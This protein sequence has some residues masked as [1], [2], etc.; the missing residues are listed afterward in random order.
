MS[1][2]GQ[3][4]LNQL[5]LVLNHF[6]IFWENV[7]LYKD[8]GKLILLD[9]EFSNMNYLGSDI[10]PFIT[11][12]MTDYCSDGELMID[13]IPSESELREMITFYC[14]FIYNKEAFMKYKDEPG[15]ADKVKN[16]SEYINFNHPLVDKIIE[17]FPLLK[18]INHCFWIWRSIYVIKYSSNEK[19]YLNWVNNRI[20]MLLYDFPNK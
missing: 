1:E 11:E 14:F 13:D 7:L 6:D 10:I 16:S 15:M 20:N 8:S 12:I 18:I 2:E 4:K 3:K 17:L 9:F 5:P 19:N